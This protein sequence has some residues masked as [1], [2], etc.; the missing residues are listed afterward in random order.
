M[1]NGNKKYTVY[2]S[3]AKREPRLMRAA[4]LS[5]RNYVVWRQIT[6]G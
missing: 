5:A 1:M 3:V 4:E 6:A 2:Y